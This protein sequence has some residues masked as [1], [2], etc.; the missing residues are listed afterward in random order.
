MRSPNPAVYDD[1]LGER[2]YDVSVQMVGL[3]QRRSAA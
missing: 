1:T 3:Q 2:L